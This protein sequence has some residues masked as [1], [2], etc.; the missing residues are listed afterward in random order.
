MKPG[1]NTAYRLGSDGRYQPIQPNA[2]GRLLSETTGLLFRVKSDGKT[3][4]LI[5]TRTGESPLVPP[6]ERARRAAEEQAAQD[7]AAARE[8]AERRTAVE[9]EITRL[10]AELE[11]LK[12]R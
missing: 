12:S 9:E 11:R 7:E 10:R 1:A 2:E 4:S 6:E 5:D 8:A 3:L